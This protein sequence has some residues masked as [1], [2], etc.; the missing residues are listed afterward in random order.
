MN[1]PKCNEEMKL[2]SYICD[3][4]YGITSNAVKV[5]LDKKQANQYGSR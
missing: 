5:T 4:D 1:C 2:I 3:N